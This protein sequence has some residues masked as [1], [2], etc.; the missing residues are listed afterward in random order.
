M[1]SHLAAQPLFR[2]LWRISL[3]TFFVADACAAAQILPNH[4]ITVP[5]PTP[6]PTLTT[7]PP[8]TT[9]ISQSRRGENIV[10]VG[11]G[12]GETL[13]TLV[14]R[15]VSPSALPVE[16]RKDSILVIDNEDGRTQKTLVTR[17]ASPSALPVEERKDSIL[18]VDH[19]NGRTQKT[20]VTRFAS[21]SAYGI[22]GHANIE[23][24]LEE[25]KVVITVVDHVNTKDI[26]GILVTRAASVSAT[27]LPAKRQTAGPDSLGSK[28]SRVPPARR[29]FTKY[30]LT[31]RASPTPVPSFPS[32]RHQ[33]RSDNKHSP[34]TYPTVSCVDADPSNFPVSR[35]QIRSK[36]NGDVF[37]Y[38]FYCHKGINSARRF[39]YFTLVHANGTQWVS[40]YSHSGILKQSHVPLLFIDT[41]WHLTYHEKIRKALFD[42]SAPSSDCPQGHCYSR[43]IPKTPDLRLKHLV[44]P[45]SL[46]TSVPGNCGYQVLEIN[47]YG[48]WRHGTTLGVLGDWHWG[49]V[50]PDAALEWI[51]KIMLTTYPGLEVGLLLAGVLGGP[52]MVALVW[53]GWVMRRR[54]RTRAKACDGRKEEKS[55]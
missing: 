39:T 43:I 31:T 41:D 49:G 55:H 14:T 30:T 35:P 22:P 11:N 23:A 47:A 7:N 45:A 24:G 16:E 28:D 51:Q 44:D 9:N 17:F 15:I 1:A 29:S 26:K 25:R 18:V 42:H 27:M 10:V 2:N 19:E 40:D 46:R 13:K 48:T 36:P 37:N 4:A 33:P 50:A 53:I 3:L 54:R 20:L 32:S 12:T 5:T 6:T 21:L 34:S 52:F 38:D 8:Y